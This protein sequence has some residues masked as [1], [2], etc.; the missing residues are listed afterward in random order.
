MR[1]DVCRPVSASRADQHSDVTFVDR[2]DEASIKIKTLR[3]RVLDVVGY[4]PFEADR[5]V[6]II[7]GRRPARRG[8]GRAAEDARGAAVRRRS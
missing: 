5:R 4:R 7:D 6:F 3:E 8:A 1:A 2:G